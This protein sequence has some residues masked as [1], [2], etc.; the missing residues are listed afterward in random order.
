MKQKYNLKDLLLENK[1]LKEELS[2]VEAERDALEVQ[3]TNVKNELLEAE[4]N[5]K[6]LTDF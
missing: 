1:K 6:A 2:E 4:S 5:L 3:L